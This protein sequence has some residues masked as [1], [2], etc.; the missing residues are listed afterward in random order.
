MGGF[1]GVQISMLLDIRAARR[2][3][4]LEASEGTLAARSTVTKS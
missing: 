2:S 4:A 1:L 3:A